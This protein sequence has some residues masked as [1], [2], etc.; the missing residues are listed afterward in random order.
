MTS[1]TT[2]YVFHND[3]GTYQGVRRGDAVQSEPVS[4]NE[5]LVV[6]WFDGEPELWLI[7]DMRSLGELQR[8]YSDQWGD[9]RIPMSVYQPVL[10]LAQ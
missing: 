2:K 3:Y 10:R 9:R 1:P 4:E 6:A 8:Y 5:R 7:W